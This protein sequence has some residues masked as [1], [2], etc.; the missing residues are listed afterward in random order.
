MDLSRVSKEIKEISADTA[1]GISVRLINDDLTSLEG[2]ITGN[3]A[4]DAIVPDPN[5]ASRGATD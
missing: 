5:D 4:A 2:S 1:S 3:S